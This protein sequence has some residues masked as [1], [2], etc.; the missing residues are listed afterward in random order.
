MCLVNSTVY[1]TPHIRRRAYIFVRVFSGDQRTVHE[2][3]CCIHVYSIPCV[4]ENWVNSMTQL[5]IHYPV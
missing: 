3:Y 1:S 4:R 5:P 2:Y